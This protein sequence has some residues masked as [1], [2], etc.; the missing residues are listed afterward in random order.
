MSRIHEALKKAEEERSTTSTVEA[1]PTP[2]DAVIEREAAVAAPVRPERSSG[3]ASEMAPVQMVAASSM[4]H[5]RFDALLARCTHPAWHMDPNTN[6][7]ANSELSPQ[8]A[9]Q[10]RTLRSRL[11]QL[12]Q[13][14]IASYCAGN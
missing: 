1:V 6:V 14:A 3:I 13:H 12:Q 11:Y 10:F 7:F 5:V 9:E 4:E 8:G 2:R